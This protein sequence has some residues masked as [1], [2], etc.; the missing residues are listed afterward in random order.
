MFQP[1]LV[2]V[3]EIVDPDDRVAACHQSRCKRG[4]DETG[5]PGNQYTHWSADRDIGSVF[6]LHSDDMVAGI[7]MVRL[8]GHSR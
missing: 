1:D 7:N 2:I 3:V 8:A 4:A 6:L 5:H